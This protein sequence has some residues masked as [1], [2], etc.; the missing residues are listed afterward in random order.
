MTSPAI[1]MAPTDS[2]FSAL[3]LLNAKG[4]RRVPVLDG[5]R[6]VGI[7]T[8]TDLAAAVGRGNPGRRGSN[9]LLAEVMT[10]K[11]VFV[12]PGDTVEHAARVLLRRK[13]SG[14]PVVDEDRVVGMVTESDLFRALCRM[15]G[16]DGRGARVELLV[17]D[18]NALVD[19]LVKQVKGFELLNI[20]ALPQP[21][22]EGWKI[23]LRLRGRSASKARSVV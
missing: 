11:P 4:I 13:I 23:V 8:K 9:L 21:R 18:D 17:P 22:G 3:S 14:L 1:T 19:C 10:R 6:L 16:V 12:A 15:L 5:D 20:A 7:V 2:A